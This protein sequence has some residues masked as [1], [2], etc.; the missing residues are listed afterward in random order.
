MFPLMNW[1]EVMHR[2][3][4]DMLAVLGMVMVGL[5]GAPSCAHAEGTTTPSIA[6]AR[7]VVYCSVAGQRSIDLLTLDADTG[8]IAK[9]ARHSVPGEPG[10]LALSP[11][12]KYLF[13]C[14][15]STGQLAS[16]HINANTGELTA[17]NCVEAGADP[18]QI[19]VD[20]TGAYLMTA[21]YV[22]AKVTVH[23][24]GSEGS[25][26]TEPVQ[27]VLTADRAHAIV[28]D[29][30][31]RFAYVPHTG[32]N[33]IFQ[34]GWDPR[35][36]ELTPLDPPQLWRK[37]QTGP[38]H[39]V[40]HP[41]L[42]IAYIDNEQSNSVTPYEQNEDGTL[43]P[44]KTVTTL[45]SDFHMTNSTAEIKI[46]P[47]GKFL[48]VS[49]RGHDS[50]AVIGVDPSGEKLS[51]IAAEKT[52]QTPRSIDIDPSG[53]FLL[54]AGEASGRLAVSKIDPQSGRLTVIGTESIG[55]KFWWVLTAE[56]NNT[57][58]KPE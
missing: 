26:S 45:P 50:I 49:N 37:E 21:Y 43:E 56:L 11:D 46:H 39:L 30:R 32:T 38:R 47:T 1:R 15:R 5:W 6:S 25:L 20:H 17:I 44:G 53:R 3:C 18:A 28:P 33:V 51:F 2:L 12:R 52:E 4:I 34:F 40:W 36:G 42:P 16:F 14:L 41:S 9:I 10:A 58:L 7:T 57:R 35:R 31:N 55:P 24:I 8:Q 19:S 48:Y 13:A 54:A 29:D 27:T 22:A 23:R